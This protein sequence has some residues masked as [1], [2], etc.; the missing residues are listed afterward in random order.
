MISYLE[1]SVKGVQKMKIIKALI[2]RQGIW[3][4]TSVIFLLVVFGTAEAGV[5]T[6]WPDKFIPVINDQN[7]NTAPGWSGSGLPD[8]PSSPVVFYANVKL[9]VGAKIK[10]MRYFHRSLGSNPGTSVNLVSVKFGQYPGIIYS[11]ESF[12]GSDTIIPVDGVYIAP[13]ERYVRS[14]RRYFV[15]IGSKN[16]ASTVWGIKVFYQ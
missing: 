5:K 13:A 14:G 4:F 15:I 6:I 16:Q 3:F 8:S 7:S 11:A 10:G 2:K 12:D 9:P 1:E